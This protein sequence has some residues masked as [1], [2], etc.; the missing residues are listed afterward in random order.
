MRTVESGAWSLLRPGRVMVSVSLQCRVKDGVV[1]CAMCE[2]VR[3]LSH[4]KEQDVYPVL[5]LQIAVLWLAST[6][7]M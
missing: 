4:E 5:L 2:C 6:C 1:V 7:P 3:V